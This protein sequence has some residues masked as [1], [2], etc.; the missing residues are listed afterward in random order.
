M[1][2]GS[3]SPVAQLVEQP[4]VN[5]LVEGSSPSG[6]AFSV[7]WLLKDTAFERTIFSRRLLVDVFGIRAW[8]ST[9]EDVI[10]H[11]L[12]WNKLSPSERQLG[13]AAG[14]YAVQSG[15]LD[16]EYMRRW[17]ANL[18][19]EVELENLIAGRTKPKST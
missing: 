19:T 1:F 17:A 6:G 3:Y 11:K 10:L 5:R 14:V 7:G 13:D 16:L 2:R 15:S 18:G 8:I 12:Y 4:A 9:A